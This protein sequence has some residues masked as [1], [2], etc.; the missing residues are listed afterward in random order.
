M[1]RFVALLA[2]ILSLSY[3]QLCPGSLVSGSPASHALTSERPSL[4]LCVQ[5]LEHPC[6]GGARLWDL[7]CGLAALALGVR[8]RLQ[9]LAS[10]GVLSGLGALAAGVN[11][12]VVILQ[13][14]QGR[15]GT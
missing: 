14:G 12:V 2:R 3:G 9:G 4:W 11:L 13:A 8:H 1:Q 5:L 6:T 10:Q 15:Q 7:L